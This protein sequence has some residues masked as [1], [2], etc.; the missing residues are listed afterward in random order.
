M[1]TNRSKVVVKKE[2]NLWERMY[3]PPILSGVSITIKH[4]FKRSA[5][6][7]YPEQTRSL[8]AVWRGQHRGPAVAEV[9]DLHPVAEQ[10]LQQRGMVLARIRGTGS[11]GD[12][13]TD[14]GHVRWL[15]GRG[16]R[17]GGKKRRGAERQHHQESARSC[18]DSRTGRRL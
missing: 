15:A 14:T 2:M 13:V 5:T 16:E 1:L 7:R 11:L 8:S 3:L 18:H 9:L 17:A 4:F 6:V 10:F 12:A